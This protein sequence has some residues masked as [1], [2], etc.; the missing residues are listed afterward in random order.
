VDAV[1]SKAVAAIDWYRRAISPHKGFSCAYRVQWG[2]RSCSGVVRA[3]LVHGGVF[4][5]IRAAVEQPHKCYA[6]ARLLA[7][8]APPEPK[9]NEPKLDKPDH[10]VPWAAAEG[11]WWCCFLP[12]AGS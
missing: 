6:A 11:S 12:F 2:G 1:A 4:G 7:A 3:A 10:C 5:G 8:Q 9:E